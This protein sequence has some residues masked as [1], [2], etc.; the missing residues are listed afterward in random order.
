MK[1][2]N[3]SSATLE[4]AVTQTVYLAAVT[5][6]WTQY[7]VITFI[8]WRLPFPL[9]ESSTGG[10]LTTDTHSSC[11][12]DKPVFIRDNQMTRHVNLCVCILV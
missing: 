9:F 4:L 8:M 7:L 11:F 5:V 2:N 6:T 12:Y 1:N 3:N 10:P